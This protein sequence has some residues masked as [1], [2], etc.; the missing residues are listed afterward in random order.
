MCMKI[1]KII[2]IFRV[3]GFGGGGGMEEAMSDESEGVGRYYQISP[4]G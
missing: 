3:G 1:Q 4:V 2:E